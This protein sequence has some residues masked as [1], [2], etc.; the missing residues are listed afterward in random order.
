MEMTRFNRRSRVYDPDKLRAC[1][2]PFVSMMIVL[3]EITKAFM[4]RISWLAKQDLQPEWIQQNST[5]TCCQP[6]RHA[7]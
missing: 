7:R 4:S 6:R 1:G 2:R 3:F 5:D